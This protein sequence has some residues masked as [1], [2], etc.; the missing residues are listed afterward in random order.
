MGEISKILGEQ[1]KSLS[2]EDKKI[3]RDQSDEDKARFQA[4]QA[5]GGVLA[6]TRKS[7]AKSEATTATAAAGAKKTKKKLL[8]PKKLSPFEAS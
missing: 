3:Y 4:E 6:P 2:E 5:A 8:K 7:K 1:W